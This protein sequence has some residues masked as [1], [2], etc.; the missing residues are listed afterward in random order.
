MTDQ[1]A[2]QLPKQVQVLIVY[3]AR[4]PKTTVFLG[5]MAVLLVALFL[6]GLAGAI[7]LLTIVAGLVTLL[8]VT[9]PRLTGQRRAFQVL[10]LALLVALAVYK[11]V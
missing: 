9:W 8:T 7:L 1:P 3:L 4:L 5:A 10:V 2:R 11:L 6:P